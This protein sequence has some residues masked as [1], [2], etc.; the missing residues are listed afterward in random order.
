MGRVPL[1]G[2]NGPNRGSRVAPREPLAVEAGNVS[3]LPTPR[4]YDRRT[5]CVTGRAREATGRSTS[6]CGSKRAD[7][8]DVLALAGRSI[9][10]A[11]NAFVGARER[12]SVETNRD[13]ALQGGSRPHPPAVARGHRATS[14][15]GPKPC[16]LAFSGIAA[17]P[18]SAHAA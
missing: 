17:S 1:G 5:E 8:N 3:R 10:A 2:W 12:S 16:P 15:V 18:P 13:E 6:G 11:P 7:R 9:A 4:P 14:P